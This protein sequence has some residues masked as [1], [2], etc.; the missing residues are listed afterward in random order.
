MIL[1]KDYISSDRDV[2]VAV[3]CDNNDVFVIDTRNGAKIVT[4]IKNEMI[5]EEIE[6]K[7]NVAGIKAGN[8][9]HR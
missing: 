6:T 4:G 8:D 1:T 2:F 9:W 5:I 7:F 3:W